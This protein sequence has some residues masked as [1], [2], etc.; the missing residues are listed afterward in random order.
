MGN[1]ASPQV[2]ETGLDTLTDVAVFGEYAVVCG[3]SVYKNAF[4]AANVNNLSSLQYGASTSFSP[5]PQ[6]ELQ[7]TCDFDGTNAVFSDGTGVYVF[8]IADG[9]P[10]AQPVAP[11][12]GEFGTVT[13]VTIAER[14]NAEGEAAGG[15]LIASASAGDQDVSLT[16][17]VPVTP[18]ANAFG[19]SASL[20]EPT[21]AYSQVVDTAGAVS[22]SRNI[23]GT[24]ALLAAAGVTANA[25]NVPEYVVSLF[26]VNTA[27]S[28]GNNGSATL[29]QLGQYATVQLPSTL[30]P[31][32]GITTF[33]TFALEP[34]FRF[35]HLIVPPIER[36]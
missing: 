5:V 30:N 27:Y 6:Y 29:S 2:Y 4:Q 1:L 25:A 35:P 10:T 17:F 13:S 23:F 12:G 36:L 18:E 8:G 34:P 9:I 22:F 20:G 15:V 26:L 24:S 21:V 28:G 31:T 3:T 19:A 16:F 33:D 14:A 32:L 7:V 11:S